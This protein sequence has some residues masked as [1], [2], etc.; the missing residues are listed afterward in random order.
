MYLIGCQ[1]HLWSICIL[2][3]RGKK[4]GTTLSPLR[5]PG[6]KTKIYSKVKGLIEY[7]GLGD[8]TYV[9]PFAGGFGI[10]IGLLHDGVVNSVLI[11]D[12]D[13]HI[14][15]FWYAALN[16]T[17]KLIELIRTTPVSIEERDHQKN[18]YNTDNASPLEDGFA[19]L[20]LNR[21]NYSGVIKGGPIGG[22]NQAGKYKID[23]R[24]NREEI[25]ER[26]LLIASFRDNIS[27]YNCDA[28]DLICNHL[29][30]QK[31]NIFLNID[32]PYVVKGSLLYTNY[33]E[34]ADHRNLQQII[35][36]NLQDVPWI[37]T[38][39]DCELIR[40]IYSQYHLEEYDIRHNV[41]NNIVKKEIVI[42]NI[43]LDKFK[44]E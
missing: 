28:S 10:G 33:F 11:N 35:S 20:F 38:Y 24:F 23:C 41:R 22:S 7:S 12:Y 31:S 3:M 34:E 19:T 26:I 21:V 8:K 6:G 13:R 44:W 17:E 43:Q 36:G 18:I 5:Y 14:Y 4:M 42:T 9:E 30:S 37:V 25:I 27:L 40:S 15:N 29:I 32:P 1:I 16:Q 2:L 39:D